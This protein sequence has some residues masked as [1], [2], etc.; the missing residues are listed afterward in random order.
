MDKGASHFEV[1]LARAGLLVALLVTAVAGLTATA[2]Y[3]WHVY[4]LIV[5]NG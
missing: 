3:L 2:A 4:R 1:T 5:L